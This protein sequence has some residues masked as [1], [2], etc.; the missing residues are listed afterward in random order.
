MSILY[1][2]WEA[3]KY[4]N[5]NAI[6]FYM[7]IGEQEL[8]LLLAFVLVLALGLLG[9]ILGIFFIVLKFNRYLNSKKYVI[10]SLHV[11]ID[12]KAVLEMLDYYGFLVD[13]VKS[14]KFKT[15]HFFNSD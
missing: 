5:H 1:D 7:D 14:H 3:M 6:Y 11:S 15:P 2:N 8:N 12:H 13:I 10:M 9:L 4:I